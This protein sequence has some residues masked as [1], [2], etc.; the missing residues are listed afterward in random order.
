[1]GVADKAVSL[2][3]EK[4]HHEVASATGLDRC[5]SQIEGAFASLES[6]RA[7]QSTPFW[8]GERM[9]HADIAVAV[10]LRFLTEAHPGLV[11]LDRY[12]ALQRHAAKHEALPVFE[13]ISQPIIPPA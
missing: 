9:G 1:M 11:A 6:E 8:F 7:A 2:L 4:R 13:R 10:A 5:R 12:P 3:Y